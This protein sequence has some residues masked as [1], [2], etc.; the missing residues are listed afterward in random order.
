LQVVIFIIDIFVHKTTTSI[1]VAV[2]GTTNGYV[3]KFLIFNLNWLFFFFFFF[4]F[5]YFFFQFLFFFPLFY[6]ILV[7]LVH[8]RRHSTPHEQCSYCFGPYHHVKDCPTAEQFSKYS[9]EHMNTQFTRSR[10]ELYCDS[11]NLGWSN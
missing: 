9:Y 2:A 3:I 8:V 4:W 10:N 7:N 1:F 5:F 6:F 11:Y